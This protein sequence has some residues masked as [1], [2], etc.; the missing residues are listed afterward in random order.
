MAWRS[1]SYQPRRSTARP[2]WMAAITAIASLINALLRVFKLFGGKQGGRS[3]SGGRQSRPRAMPKPAGPIDRSAGSDGGIARLF[4]E[5]ASDISVTAGGRVV[6]CL[7]DDLDDSDGSG[8]HQVFLVE[9]TSALTI[10]ISHN[11]KFGRVPVR[12]GDVLTFRGD[13]QWTA[14]GGTVHWTH[15]DPR[16]THVDGWIERDGKR[17]G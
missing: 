8:Q 7:P 3:G 15:R 11:L 12:E 1:R 14:K 5:R 10:K 13:Y 6:K 17:Y 4:A 2:P 9:L 16:G